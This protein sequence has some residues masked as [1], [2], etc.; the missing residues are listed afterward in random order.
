VVLRTVT[1]LEN[2]SASAGP[3]GAKKT[4]LSPMKTKA[5]IENGAAWSIVSIRP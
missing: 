4:S 5:S 2:L 3:R 1:P